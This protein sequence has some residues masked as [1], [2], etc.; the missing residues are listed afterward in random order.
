[1]TAPLRRPL[2]LLAALAS[3]VIWAVNYPAMKVAFRE[4]SPLAFTGWRF[5]LATTFLLGEA[6]VRRE[7]LVPP[8]GA[9]GLGLVLALSGV[10]LYQWLYALGLA[11]TSSFS[12]ALLNSVSPLVAV[13]LVVLLG[14][15][16]MSP[17]AGA[18]SLVAW[19]GVAL[20][21]ASARGPDFGSTAGNLMCLG[22]AVSWAVYNVASARAGRFLSPL[23]AQL[24][25]FGGGTVLILAYALPDMLRQDYARVSPSAWAIVVLSALLPL[26]VAFRLWLGAVRT[27]GVAHA[28]SFG[29][30]VPVLAGIASAIFTGE[31]F[32]AQKVLSA[33]VVLAGLALTRIGRRADRPLP[34]R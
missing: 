9:R 7:R 24:A 25:A 13:L 5:V 26:V 10:G 28:T 22:A 31:R 8:P 14:W 1:M 15:E 33:A 18:G 23:G 30:L 16:R 34:A 17:L 21:V 6:L 4:L 19:G 32:H 29:F 20:F 27:L 3:V 11:S 2:A 12:A